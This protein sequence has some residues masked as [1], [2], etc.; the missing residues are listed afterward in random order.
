MNISEKIMSFIDGFIGLTGLITV[1]LTTYG[2]FTRFVLKISIAWSD[3]L[4]R[5]IFVWAYFIGTALLYHNSGLMRL[6]IADDTMKRKGKLGAYRI[7]CIIQ[8]IAMIIFSGIVGYYGYVMIMAQV[9][10]GQMTTTSSTPAWVSPLGFLIGMV[11]LA[12]FAA[13]KLFRHLFSHN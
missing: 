9:N 12:A 7:L 6:E 3:E 4:L 5:T 11:L 10:S 2:V 8:D 1:L 13:N